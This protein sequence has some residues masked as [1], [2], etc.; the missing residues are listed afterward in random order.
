MYNGGYGNRRIA[1][2]KNDKLVAAKITIIEEIPLE[3]VLALQH[4]PFVT[5]K[6]SYDL[7]IEDLTEYIKQIIAAP[8]KAKGLTDLFCEI[9]ADDQ[10]DKYTI[11]TQ[12]SRK[13]YIKFEDLQE[14]G[15][16]IKALAGNDI[17]TD[18]LVYLLMTKFK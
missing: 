17:S 12:D 11:P 4:N 15:K 13:S 10:I 8:L 16:R 1:N 6:A 5:D 3:E 7:S 14:R 9:F 2:V 18:M